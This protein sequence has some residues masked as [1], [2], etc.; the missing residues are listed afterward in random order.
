VLE[1]AGEE[2]QRKE[3]GLE[4]LSDG[5]FTYKVLQAADE[6]GKQG[7]L[8]LTGVVKSKKKITIKDS[9]KISGITYRITRIGEKAFSGDKKLTTVIIGRNVTIIDK[10]AFFNTP[11]LKKVTIRSK[12]LKQ[13]GKKAFYRK[14]GKQITFTVPVG[15]KKAYE[16][17]IKKAKTNRYVIK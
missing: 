16:K 4:A 6:N 12:K 10:N 3:S 15:K 1:A 5:V 14:K 11:R 7:K 8:M 9:A 2:E 13:I 17:Y